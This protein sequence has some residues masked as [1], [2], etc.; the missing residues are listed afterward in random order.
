MSECII[1]IKSPTLSKKAQ[2][3]LAHDGI[4][5]ELIGIDPSITKRGCAYALS[6]ECGAAA[7]A[8]DILKRRGITF[9]EVIGGRNDISR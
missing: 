9:G 6:I 2:R 5:A 3:I 4:S 8:S 1:P 7:R